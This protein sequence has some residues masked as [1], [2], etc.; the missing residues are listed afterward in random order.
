MA[1]PRS[2]TG[3]GIVNGTVYYIKNI[4]NG[5]YL[6]VK[7]GTDANE[8][9]V[10]T[11]TFNA[12]AAQ[13]WRAERNTD[14]SYTFYSMKSNNGS[15]LD[16]TNGNVDIWS[17]YSTA[18]YQ[19]FTLIRDTSLPYGGTY[20]IKSGSQY[21]VWDLVNDTVKMQSSGNGLNA[22]WSFEPVTKGHA[23]IYTLYY[24]EDDGSYLD[25]RGAASTFTS[26]CSNMGYQPFHLVNYVASSSY[27]YLK[28]DMIWVFR[29]H[30]L[31]GN[32]GPLATICYI[33]GSGG[34][35]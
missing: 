26:A 25:T 18:S 2:M 34:D 27:N 29:G 23:D 19:K 28:S 13:K 33:S 6:D 16:I 32:N 7:N 4:Y 9:D 20:Q 15:V 11:Y 24:P 14:G 3:A 1:Q 10:W 12:T 30:G 8:T 17:Y 35:K 21:M 31:E 22:L 5:K